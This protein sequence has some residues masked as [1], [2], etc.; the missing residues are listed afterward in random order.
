MN[1]QLF[2]KG[3]K[4]TAYWVMDGAELSGILRHIPSNVG[5]SWI[6]ETEKSLQAINPNCSN[7]ERIV[8]FKE[9]A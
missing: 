5:D 2:K 8:K 1:D 3:D 4:V 9:D 7:F 6:I